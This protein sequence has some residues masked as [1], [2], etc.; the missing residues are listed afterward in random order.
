MSGLGDFA[1]T[2]M[3]QDELMFH[4][5]NFVD[6]LPSLSVHV[7]TIEMQCQTGG[8][9]AIVQLTLVWQ[10]SCCFIMLL[11]VVHY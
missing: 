11:M 10:R 5:H 9:F 4:Y 1:E 7:G 8:S 6:E 3:F 2:K